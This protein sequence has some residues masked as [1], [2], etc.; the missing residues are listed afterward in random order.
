MGI[1]L[2]ICLCVLVIIE[3]ALL[4]FFIKGLLES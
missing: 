1:A 4:L 2:T 3:Y